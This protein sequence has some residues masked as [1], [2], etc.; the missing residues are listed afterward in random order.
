MKEIVC[1]NCGEVGYSAYEGTVCLVC[2]NLPLKNC[3]YLGICEYLNKNRKCSYTKKA[4]P[5]TS[6]NPKKGRRAK[7]VIELEE[8]R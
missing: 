3:Y 6:P 8:R 7:K 2:K 5:F 4:C 1:S